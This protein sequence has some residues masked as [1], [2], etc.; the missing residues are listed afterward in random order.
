MKTSKYVGKEFAG[1][2]ITHIGIAAVQ[3]ARNKYAYHRSYYYLAE[4]ATSDGKCTKQIRLNARQMQMLA[5]G[6]FDVEAFADK[7]VHTRKATVRTNY[8]FN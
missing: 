3:S 7:H 1:W 6:K 2:L 8:A 5:T 4:R